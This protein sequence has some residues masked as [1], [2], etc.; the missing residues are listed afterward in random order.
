MKYIVTGGAGFIGSFVTD[1]LVAEGH[2]VLVID[3]LSGGKKENV[4][5]K[6]QLEVKD[7]TR[8]TEIAPLFKGVSGVVHLAAIPRVPL[9][10]ADPIG[11]SEANIM[12]TLNVYW[13]A[14]EAGVGRVVVASSSSVYGSQKVMPFV[15]TMIPSPLSPYALQKR[16]GEEYARLFKELYGLPIVSLR[17]FNV[18]GPRVSVDSDYSLVIGKFIKQRLQGEPLTI[19]GDGEQTR[20]FSYV[21]DTA[22]AVYRALTR[23]NLV[24]GEI[25]NIGSPV[26]YS[27]NYIA[28]LIGGERKYLPARKGDML[29]TQADITLAHKLLDWQITTPFEEGVKKV[30]DYFGLQ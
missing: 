23:P 20:G 3:N 22:D 6:A 24:G 26:S 2:E 28:S 4:N 8:Y 25:I 7:I 13:A 30:K 19:F 27:V 11:T 1:Q 29:H 21:T 16:V 17:F 5:P 12:G 14:K 10:V 9:S 15:E 18:Y